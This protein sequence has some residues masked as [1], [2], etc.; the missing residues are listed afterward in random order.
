MVS[1]YNDDFTTPKS[2]M[3]YFIEVRRCVNGTGC[4]RELNTYPVPVLAKMKEIVIVVPDSAPDKQKWYKYV[5]YDHTSCR[6][7]E[8]KERNYS[9]LHGKITNNNGECNLL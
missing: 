8:L 7:G 5:V 6:C 4:S 2:R 3:P 1:I 9:T